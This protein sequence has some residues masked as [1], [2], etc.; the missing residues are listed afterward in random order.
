MR[1][2]SPP[3]RPETIICN[4]DDIEKYHPKRIDSEPVYFA[5]RPAAGIKFIH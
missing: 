5:S 1:I 4:S 2:N 3:A